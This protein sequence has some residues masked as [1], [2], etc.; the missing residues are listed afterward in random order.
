[1]YLCLIYLTMYMA[2]HI[3][4]YDNLDLKRYFVQ[5]FKNK[6]KVTVKIKTYMCMIT[7]IEHL[8]R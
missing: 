7:R 4:I 3:C 5:V 1:M 6:I 8:F 2:W